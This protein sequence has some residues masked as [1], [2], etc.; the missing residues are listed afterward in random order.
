MAY[1]L[2]SVS[3]LMTCCRK[4]STAASGFGACQIAAGDANENSTRRCRFQDL[5]QAPST[6]ARRRLLPRS[7]LD[8]FLERDRLAA[9]DDGEGLDLPALHG[10]DRHLRILAIAF[11][12]ELDPAGG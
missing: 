10:E 4:I 5:R 6:R 12:V 1:T 11:R 7:R 2:P 3:P 9:L 8:E